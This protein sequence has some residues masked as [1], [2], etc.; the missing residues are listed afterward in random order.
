[1]LRSVATRPNRLFTP[2][3]TDTIVFENVGILLLVAPCVT[4]KVPLTTCA[5]ASG[6]PPRRAPASRRRAR[7]AAQGIPCSRRSS[8]EG[9][10][11]GRPP[12]GGRRGHGPRRTCRRS[13]TIPCAA[14]SGSCRDHRREKE[15]RAES[16]RFGKRTGKVERSS[17]ASRAFHPL[18][19]FSFIRVICPD[20]RH[21]TRTNS[22][23]RF[24]YHVTPVSRIAQAAIVRTV[25]FGR[26]PGRAGTF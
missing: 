3:K 5:T 8:S 18:V 13:R 26:E 22:H 10:G 15:G 11:Q 17:D 7:Q 14:R 9:A 24:F 19:S 25:V 2:N 21:A 6:R 23:D 4:R 12:G 16:C 20:R 1:M